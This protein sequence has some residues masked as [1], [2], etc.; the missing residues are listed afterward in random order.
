MDKDLDYIDSY[1]NGE[2]TG[3]DK[4]AFEAKMEASPILKEEV[5]LQEALINR[6]ERL[7]LIEDIQ[8]AANKY[9]SKAA[10]TRRKY[11][12]ALGTAIISTAL[13]TLFFYKQNTSDTKY[14][15]NTKQDQKP[16]INQGN[17]YNKTAG[18]DIKH[19]VNADKNKS[20]A[21]ENAL[22]DM[23]N[24]DHS[25]TP[26][27]INSVLR[28]KST[29]IRNTQKVELK[30]PGSNSKIRIEP[31]SIVDQN[32]KVVSGEIE[33]VYRSYESPADLALAGIS[34]N[35]DSLNTTYQLSSTGM[36]EVR[37]YQAGEQLQ[38]SPDKKITVEFDLSKRPNLNPNSIHY[39]SD[40]EKRWAFAQ[41]AGSNATPSQSTV[42]DQNT[43]AKS[44][45]FNTKRAFNSNIEIVNINNAA[46]FFQRSLFEADSW[47]QNPN[48]VFNAMAGYDKTTYEDRLLSEK[49]LNGI[50]KKEAS[51]TKIEKV[52]NIGFYSPANHS[53][54]DKN[55]FIIRFNYIPG[56]KDPLPQNHELKNLTLDDWELEKQ[57]P[58]L[59]EIINS[60]WT[61][62][63]I[64]Y[65]DDTE[66]FTFHMKGKNT[67]VTFTAK[68]SQIA[69]L[70]RTDRSEA[71]Q[72]IIKNFNHDQQKRI[73]L[74]NDSMRKE[75]QVLTKK[76]STN[77]KAFYE[78]LKIML[79]DEAMI[80][81]MQRIQFEIK[82]D[83]EWIPFINQYKKEHYTTLNERLN[84]LSSYK[85][86]GLEAIESFISKRNEEL[87]RVSADVY[88]EGISNKIKTPTKSNEKSKTT[89][90]INVSRFGIFNLGSKHLNNKRVKI[91][92]RFSTEKN[93]NIKIRRIGLYNA[94]INSIVFYRKN[95]ISV[96]KLK[97]EHMIVLSEDGT[98][99]VSTEKI[100]AQSVPKRGTQEIELKLL[101]SSLSAQLSRY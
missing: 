20:D 80:A 89:L 92:P 33:L 12:I 2:L 65:N 100:D 13:I 74:L 37:A 66:L 87:K 43:F 60:K 18:N 64:D 24:S 27:G 14:L 30:V 42:V 10:N 68:N 73:K 55:K 29:I 76:Q 47:L 25:I 97:Q 35:Y 95:K 93:R 101:N 50:I 94:E 26:A 51:A 86:G 19:S 88:Y 49:Y 7:G 59:S 11:F 70:K 4:L 9:E 32:G 79:A 67:P 63:S 58:R 38:L 69:A 77:E 3:P 62:L 31:N 83:I 28:R 22:P 99:Y 90:T 39:Y 17:S 98:I 45:P 81:E 84:E 44:N 16:L 15:S 53:S 78:C 40:S 21:E 72:E 85:N 34:M 91:T 1:L 36:I 41:K 5:K 54:Q 52:L 48:Y 23:P 82:E 6:V 75:Y 8:V 56:S 71:A 57:T 61:D 46:S 96:H